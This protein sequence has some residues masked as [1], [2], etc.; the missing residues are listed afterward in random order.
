[1]TR[2][3]AQVQGDRLAGVVLTPADSRVGGPEVP[4]TALLK[5][6]PGQSDLEYGM[7]AF[8]EILDSVGIFPK[9]VDS[10]PST[11]Q[12][13]GPQQGHGASLGGQSD[14]VGCG[15]SPSSRSD[16]RSPPGVDSLA[17][18]VGG[19]AQEA[20][21]AHEV[22]GSALGGVDQVSQTLIR[23]SGRAKTLLIPYQAGQS[24]M[25]GSGPRSDARKRI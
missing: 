20:G 22:S 1:M 25:E 24:G 12:P 9:N 7:D 11:E 2:A 19:R 10:G 6:K 15:R 13:G 14:P 21:P 8:G 23:R 18:Q 16:I 4:G 3:Q 5:R 17:P